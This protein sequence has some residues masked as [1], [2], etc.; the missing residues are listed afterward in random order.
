M[1]ALR[2][3]KGWVWDENDKTYKQILAFEERSVHYQFDPQQHMWI[4]PNY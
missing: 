2:N 4:V 3:P 1:N